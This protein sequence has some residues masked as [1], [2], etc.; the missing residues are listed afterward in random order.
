MARI[1]QTYQLLVARHRIG[2]SP[3][4]KRPGVES[5]ILFRGIDGQLPQELLK[6]GLVPEFFTR[7][8][9]VKPIPEELADAVKAVTAGV[10]CVNCR[11][12]HGLVERTTAAA[13]VADDQVSDEVVSMASLTGHGGEEESP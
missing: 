5:T 9:E 2:S 7:S 13:A 3:G 6:Q 10:S 12:C 4:G 1:E 11:H 8:G